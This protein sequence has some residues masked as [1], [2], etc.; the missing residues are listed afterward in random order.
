M[1]V[2]EHEE[3]E[4]LGIEMREPSD[5]IR[6]EEA[7]N[8][9]VTDSSAADDNESS[10]AEHSDVSI[11]VRPHEQNMGSVTE[12]YGFCCG[13]YI[14]LRVLTLFPF[15]AEPK[16]ILLPHTDAEDF[17][18]NGVTPGQGKGKTLLK[19]HTQPNHACSP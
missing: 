11:L 1:S 2:A 3:A 9:V 5:M 12:E 17:M 14:D 7:Q 13:R 19:S 4:M 15:T 10:T 8:P 6:N 16:I 18:P